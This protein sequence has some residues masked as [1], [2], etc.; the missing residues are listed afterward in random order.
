[1][2]VDTEDLVSNADIARLAGVTRSA[3]TNWQSRHADFPAPV[4]SF[5]N[6]K[7]KL[8]LWP[9][10]RDW[11]LTPRTITYNVTVTRTLPPR[12]LEESG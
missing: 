11:I 9:Q 5:G 3:V 8:Y 1:M 12:V 7:M 6:E 2:L 10:V 4:A